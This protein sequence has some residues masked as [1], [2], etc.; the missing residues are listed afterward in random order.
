MKSPD[1][2][3][4]S[5][6]DPLA[7]K[8]AAS[9]GSTY[10]LRR[11]L[12]GGGM[13]RVFLAHDRSLGRDIVVKLLL[14]ELAAGISIT[15]FRREIALAARLQHPNIVT[16]LSAGE[17]DGLPYF[18]MPFVRGESLRA[19]LERGERVEVRRA[20]RILRDVACALARAHEE[21]VV[22]RDIKP[23]NILLSGGAAMVTDFGVAKA[24]SSSRE[25]EDD[26][27]DSTLTVAGTS[28]GTP[29]YISPEQA[30]ADPAIDHR[31]D[32]YSLGVAAY[33][34]LAGQLPF[35][36]ASHREAITAHLTKTPPPLAS[37]REDIPPALAE[38]VMRCME[39]DP[40]ARPQS[41]DQIVDELDRISPD[42]RVTADVEPAAPPARPPW[43]SRAVIGLLVATS[44]GL[45]AL[46]YMSRSAQPADTTAAPPS[47]A[48]SVPAAREAYVRG[49]DY[50]RRSRQDSA[51]A[52]F[53]TPAIEAFEEA[54]RLDPRYAQAFA[55]LAEARFWWAALDPADQRRASLFN[56]A[57]D[58]AIALDPNLPEVRAAQALRL[59]H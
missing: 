29:D 58:S 20:I 13:S 21:G 35:P 57:L 10:E 54:V 2:P 3:H 49:L 33:H 5:A 1:S 31:S 12:G 44:L 41:A 30:T 36:A 34:L 25:P 55:R 8:L 9:L 52:P 32:I 16:V 46:N 56:Q 59:D 45:A 40:T 6:S 22:H 28:L 15:R 51:N 18:T 27:G 53:L 7:Q 37:R 4:P 38:L 11:E 42:A 17:A 39:K 19:L 26:P 43:M 47:P 23:A 24:L 50:F 48:T 14:P